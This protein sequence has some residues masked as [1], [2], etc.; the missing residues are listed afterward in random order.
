MRWEKFVI[1]ASNSYDP[2]AHN[3][4]IS[5]V[6]PNICLV[7]DLMCSVLGIGFIELNKLV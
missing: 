1:G 5:T 4:Y 6:I 7:F 2:L 3:S